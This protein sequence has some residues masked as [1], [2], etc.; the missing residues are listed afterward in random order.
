MAAGG[1]SG[2][3]AAIPV[4]AVLRHTRGTRPAEPRPYNEDGMK[5]KT[6]KSARILAG[7]LLAASVSSAGALDLRPDG[8]SVQGSWGTN[9][10]RMAG[11]GLVWDWDWERLRRKAAITGRTEL[12]ANFWRADDFGGGHQGWTQLV[13]LPTLRFELSQGR[14]PLYVELGV[15]ASWL[16]RDYRTP[17]RGFSTRWNFY[18]VVGVGH[19]FG[20]QRE[21]ELGVRWVHVSNAGLRDPNPGQ[22]FVQLRYARRF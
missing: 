5:T 17:H 13:L 11:A 10:A 18:D 7:A 21:H 15:G 12:L 2:V 19:S 8:V 20:V 1:G 4:A 6:K 14:S 9:S 3:S 22:D 16:N